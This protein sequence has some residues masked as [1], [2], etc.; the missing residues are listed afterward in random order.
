MDTS[1]TGIQDY[2]GEYRRYRLCRRYRG[3]RGY[4]NTGDTGN[5]E[6]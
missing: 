1:G 4:R 5:M 3:L 6:K 2:T